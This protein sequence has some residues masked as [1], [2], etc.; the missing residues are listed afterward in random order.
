MFPE[1]RGAIY[2]GRWNCN[3]PKG[4]WTIHGEALQTTTEA[5]GSVSVLRGAVKSTGENAWRTARQRATRSCGRKSTG[6][7]PA[8]R[9]RIEWSI[10]GRCAWMRIWRAGAR[11]RRHAVGHAEPSRS[12]TNCPFQH[13]QVSVGW[14]NDRNTRSSG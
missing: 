2:I 12:F 8:I 13:M 5:G 1:N 10:L 6:P 9:R 14:R 4:G 11:G 7:L 3:H